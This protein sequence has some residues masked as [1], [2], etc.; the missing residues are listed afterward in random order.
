VAAVAASTMGE[1]GK[2][3]ISGALVPKQGKANTTEQLGKITYWEN[4]GV[5]DPG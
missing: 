5:I 2:G 4:P 1:R 3:K